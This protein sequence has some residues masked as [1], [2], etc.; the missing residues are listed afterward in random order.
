MGDEALKA[1]ST[2]FL[3]SV[4][5]YPLYLISYVLYDQLERVRIMDRSCLNFLEI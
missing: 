4:L 2:D 5:V 1:M 3:L